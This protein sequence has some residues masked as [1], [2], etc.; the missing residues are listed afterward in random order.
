ML[1]LI[2]QKVFLELST[3]QVIIEYPDKMLLMWLVLL[4]VFNPGLP[5][6]ES[7]HRRQIMATQSC[8]GACSQNILTD[9][10]LVTRVTSSQT[11]LGGSVQQQQVLARGGTA[12]GVFGPFGAFSQIFG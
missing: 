1:N 7:R 2:K 11:G 10:G 9:G 12:G 6:P 5:R 3:C 4:L 8:E